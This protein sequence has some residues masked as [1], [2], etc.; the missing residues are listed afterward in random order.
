[1]NSQLR[2]CFN[3]VRDS[4][5]AALAH[6]QIWFTLR[7]A[8]KAIDTHLDDM[9]DHRYVD[10]FHASNSGNYKLMFIET[11]ALFDSDTNTNNIRTLKDH[12][13][14]NGLSVLADKFSDQLNVYSSLVSNIKAIRGK[15]IAH[16]EANVDPGGL[17]KKHGIK[18]DDIRDLLFKSGELLQELESVLNN[19]S[20]C[21][22]VSPT[23]RWERATF[24][25]LDALKAER[26]S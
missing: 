4:Q 13:H 11:A 24:N 6:Y 15:I 17:Y 2:D 1:M 22:S 3:N 25:L 7:G 9:N 14:N 12:M 16:K 26:C 21:S 23:D 8:G 19:N 20:S 18:P 5:V 10:F